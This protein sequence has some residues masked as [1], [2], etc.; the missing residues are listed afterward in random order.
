MGRRVLLGVTLAVLVAACA[1]TTIIGLRP[2]DYDVYGQR[3]MTVVPP[4]YYGYHRAV[5]E[6]LGRESNGRSFG[7]IDWYMADSIV[8]TTDR[9]HYGGLYMSPVTIII[10]ATMIYQVTPIHELTHYLAPHLSHDDPLFQRCA[11]GA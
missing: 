9:A 5:D 8:R 4:I 1:A 2:D 6:C 7:W 11:G 10:D 3:P